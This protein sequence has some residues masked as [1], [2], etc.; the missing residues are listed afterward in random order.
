MRAFAVYNDKGTVGVSV[1]ATLSNDK[2][3]RKVDLALEDVI[4]PFSTMEGVAEVVAKYPEMFPEHSFH[5]AIVYGGMDKT[6]LD[7][8]V[9]NDPI[10]GASNKI[11]NPPNIVIHYKTKTESTEQVEPPF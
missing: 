1:L 5:R 11:R 4:G 10:L 9:D 2:D 8:E 6:A 3:W 7:I